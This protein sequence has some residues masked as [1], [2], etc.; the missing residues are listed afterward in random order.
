M[1]AMAAAGV[2]VVNNPTEAGIRMAEL[3]KGL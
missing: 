2:H 1:E 3:V